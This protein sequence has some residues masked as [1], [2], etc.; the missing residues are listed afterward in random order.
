MT[1]R[2]DLFRVLVIGTANSARSQIAEALILTRGEKRPKGRVIAESGGTKPA[3]QMN[4][5]GVVALMTHGIGWG[6][7]K[8]K[9]ID[10]FKGERFDL[11]ITVCDF[12]RAAVG[13]FPGAKAQV[14]WGLPD[15]SEHIASATARA[16]FAGTCNALVARV[17]ALLR[18]PLE[19][20]DAAELKEKAQAVH[21]GLLA[22][23]QRSSARLRRPT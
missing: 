22:P 21:D 8:P 6:R 17:N 18:L 23:S 12:A 10:T 13:E 7:R 2:P 5:Y 19:T 20:M 11:V 15:P 3:V 16:A 4:E 14:H 9:S 1:G